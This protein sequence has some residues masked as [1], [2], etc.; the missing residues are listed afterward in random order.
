MS[1]VETKALIERMEQFEAVK[2]W[3]ADDWSA[4][5][6]RLRTSIVEGISVFLSLFDDNPKLKRIFC[7][8]KEAYDEVLNADGKYGRPLPEMEQIIEQGKVLALNFPLA[9]NP[10]TSRMIACLLKLD[11]QR[12]VQHRISTMA[13]HPERS[14]RQILFLCD[15]YHYLATAGENNPNGDEKFFSLSRQAKCIPIV[16]TQSV[17]SLKSALPGD[18]WQTLLQC[19][20]TKLFLTQSDGFTAKYASDLAGRKRRLMPS[21]SVSETGQDVRVGMLTG[22]SAAHKASVGLNKSYTEQLQP[23]FDPRFL[24]ELGTVQCMV[25]AFDGLNPIPP[26]LCYLKPWYL[27]RQ[28]S[29]FEQKE[30]GLI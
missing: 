7:P 14:W 2:R 17:N 9:V 10:A 8:P 3:A 12:A 4:I 16:A 28:M 1:E 13:A 23:Q 22:R 6:S 29:Y 27:D 18:T 11:F 24:M 25:M 15:E 20:R 26:Q 5:D 19:F 30:K 21:Y